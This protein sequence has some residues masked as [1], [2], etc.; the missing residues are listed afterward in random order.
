MSKLARRHGVL[1]LT[2]AVALTVTHLTGHLEHRS[3]QVQTHEVILLSPVPA[4]P[5]ELADLLAINRGA[6]AQVA[7][8]GLVSAEQRPGVARTTASWMAQAGDALSSGDAY[9]ARQ[10]AILEDWHSA[11]AD[12]VNGR[13][14]GLGR[15]LAA[16]K[17]NADLYTE[18]V[19][20]IDTKTTV[21]KNWNHQEDLTQ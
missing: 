13:P 2:L 14:G 8:V 1:L 7:L 21:T 10:R 19:M 20:E 6:A 15:V 18:M 11:L 16:S 3:P 4:P 9:A 17:V 12:Y 5:F